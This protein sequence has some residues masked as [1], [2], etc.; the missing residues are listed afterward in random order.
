MQFDQ[1]RAGLQLR[2]GMQ[3]DRGIDVEPVCSWGPGC[4]HN[5]APNT[6][7]GLGWISIGR[8]T[9]R[10]FCNLLQSHYIIQQNENVFSIAVHPATK[11]KRF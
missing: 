1:R 7:S 9:N 6:L 3:F 4:T 10:R 8:S 11:R 5:H 2:A